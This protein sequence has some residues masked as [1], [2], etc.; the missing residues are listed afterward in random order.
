MLKTVACIGSA[1]PHA[2]II[3]DYYDMYITRRNH[4]IT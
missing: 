1:E 3:F 2:D 4:M